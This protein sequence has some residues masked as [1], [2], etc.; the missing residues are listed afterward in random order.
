MNKKR[1]LILAGILIAS[2]GACIVPYAVLQ[3]P[4][5][6]AA[7]TACSEA[8]LDLT[9][10]RGINE[11]AVIAVQSQ[12]GSSFGFINRVGKAVIAPQFAE[13][14]NFH[15]G[16]CAVRL[17]KRW[18]FI[19]KSGEMV[20]APKYTRAL[21]FAEGLAPVREG[22]VWCYIDKK[23]NQKI[24][25]S[26]WNGATTFK[27]GVA[28][29]KAGN[30]HS[31]INA[32]GEY[33]C[34]NFDEISGP[35]ENFFRTKKDSKYGFVNSNGTFSLE[36]Q[37]S[38]ASNFSQS[39]AAVEK[40]GKWGYIDGFSRLVIPANFDTAGDFHN[41]VAVISV[42][43][44]YGLIDRRGAYRLP[45]AY[46]YLSSILPEQNV[47]ASEATTA[48]LSAEGMTPVNDGS[49]W[50]FA[51]NNGQL[52]IKAQFGDVKPFSEG[53][54]SVAVFKEPAAVASA[55]KQQRANAVSEELPEQTE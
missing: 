33:I 38:D 47:P 42:A 19:N 20:I 12:Y 14:A 37:F 26:D 9:G 1:I 36:P 17:N 35:C 45:P 11:S 44:K 24:A 30:Q 51:D 2:A 6:A 8:M 54:A 28:I 25:P 49:L 18:G 10:V 48:W 16:L 40:N 27:N 55:M 7:M 43:G 5:V 31:L 32:R 13:T 39:L 23:G 46:K 41:G 52:V 21:D 3:D 29:V 4:L 50:G 34:R 53:L 15:E 22:L